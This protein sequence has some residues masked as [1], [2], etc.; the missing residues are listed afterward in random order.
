MSLLFSTHERETAIVGQRR[1]KLQTE[2]VSP[3]SPLNRQTLTWVP[4]NRDNHP[5][6]FLSRHATRMTAWITATICYCDVQADL[7]DVGKTATS[8]DPHTVAM[9]PACCPC[10]P[11]TAPCDPHAVHSHVMQPAYPVCDPHDIAST[12]F[13]PTH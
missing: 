7:T 5:L 1:E 4:R 3:R 2:F 6:T 9:R 8:C 12:M 10:D 13:L 11:H